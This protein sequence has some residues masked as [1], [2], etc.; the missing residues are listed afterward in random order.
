MMIFLH[1]CAVVVFGATEDLRFNFRACSSTWRRRFAVEQR[2][3][4]FA[5]M[6][7]SSA[8]RSSRVHDL[9]TLNNMFYKVVLQ[10]DVGKSYFFKE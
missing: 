10:T 4:H 6:I 8:R 2:L 3:Q 9:Y 7:L 1:M 5:G